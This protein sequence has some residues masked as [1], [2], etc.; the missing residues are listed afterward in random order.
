[1]HKLTPV[2]IASHAIPQY[3]EVSRSISRR[4][5]ASILTEEKKIN[6]SISG[7]RSEFFLDIRREI[8]E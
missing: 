2:E 3:F 4:A 7:F 5:Y 8:T 6:N 1:M